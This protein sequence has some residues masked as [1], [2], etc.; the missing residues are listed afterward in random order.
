LVEIG[1]PLSINE[2]Y[3][4]LHGKRSVCNNSANEVTISFENLNKAKLNLIIRA[5]NDG[6]AFRYGFPDKEGSYIVKEELTSYKIPSNTKRWMERFDLSS[7]VLY[8]YMESDSIQQDWGYPALFNSADSTCW[9]LIHE[10]DDN[11][12]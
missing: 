2:S 8:S 3:T 12:S 11:R 1:K 5:Y 6:V 4:A 9:F 10:A 7:E